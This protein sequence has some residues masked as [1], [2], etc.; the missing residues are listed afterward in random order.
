MQGN[1]VGADR[2]SPVLELVMKDSVR[3][4]GLMPMGNPSDDLAS[5]V[6]EYH[7][8]T[9]SRSSSEIPQSSVI[10]ARVVCIN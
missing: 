8:I 1:L 3:M 5:Q 7:P 10:W 6:L 4:A 2:W 9:I